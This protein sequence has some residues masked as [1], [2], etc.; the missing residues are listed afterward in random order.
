M[1]IDLC[2]LNSRL[3]RNKEEAA[4]GWGMDWVLGQRGLKKKE[5]RV[6]G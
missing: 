4:E 6:Q 5:W 1:L 3:E 2:I